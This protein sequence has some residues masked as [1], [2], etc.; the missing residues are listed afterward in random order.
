MDNAAIILQTL[1][2]HLDHEVSLILYGR[3]AL[4]LGFDT[5]PVETAHSKDVD[6]IIPLS[7]VEDMGRDQQF[8][9]AQEATNEQLRL[10]GLYIT[11]LFRADWENEIVPISR[12]TL[13]WLRLFRP[14]TLDLVLTKMMR[15]A[16]PQDMA[17]AKFMIEHDKITRK[18]L[19]AAFAVMNPIEL[20][21]LRDAFTTA[22]PIVTGFTAA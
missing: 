20:V 6:C 8:W 12:P 13:K 17:D 18:Q 16:D 9:D 14:A 7:R 3:A 1:D 5:A 15:G 10:R 21:E 2:S 19:E 22:R 11:H 4:N